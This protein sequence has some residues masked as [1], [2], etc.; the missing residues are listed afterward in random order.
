MALQRIIPWY[1]GVDSARNL[2][3]GLF[4]DEQAHDMTS[5]LSVDYAGERSVFSLDQLTRENTHICR[6]FCGMP[7]GGQ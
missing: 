3:A 7:K 5:V 1:D 2:V 4:R 6:T